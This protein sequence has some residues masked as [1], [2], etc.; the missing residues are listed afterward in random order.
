[1]SRDIDVKV[2]G[3]LGMRKRGKNDTVQNPKSGRYR[4]NPIRR[5][6]NDGVYRRNRNSDGVYGSNCN[7]DGDDGDDSNKT[8]S[9]PPHCFILYM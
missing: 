5:R 4:V 9:P 2:A 8:F 1:M 7:S 6:R 3:S